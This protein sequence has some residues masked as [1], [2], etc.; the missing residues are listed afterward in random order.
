[1]SLYMLRSEM[2]RT[3]PPSGDTAG[4]TLKLVRDGVGPVVLGDVGKVGLPHRLGPFPGQHLD[5]EPG[6]GFQGV[7][8]AS[9][10]MHPLQNL[11]D[12]LDAVRVRDE[13][14]DGLAEPVDA[15]IAH[16]GECPD[17]NEVSLQ[18][19]IAK[20]HLRVGIDAP[21]GEVLGH[22]L[23]EPPGGRGGERVRQDALPVAEEDVDLERVHQLVRQDVVQLGVGSGEGQ[24][25]APLQVLRHAPGARAE[26]LG[27]DVGL[28]EVAV[29]GVENDRRAAPDVV[30]QH[31]GQPVVG[32]LGHQ[33]RVVHGLAGSL[34]V[35]DVE[36]LG[37]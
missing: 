15:D 28:L 5:R 8:H 13:L 7:L 37:A 26:Q 9:E 18:R 29:G 25:D 11:A 27:D 20:P 12:L 22:S 16:V 6:G 23:H 4:A 17:R 31:R 1:M 14:E 34:V 35:V 19:R 24:E 32:A 2:K 30:V 21:D 10:A 3:R 33:G 36:M